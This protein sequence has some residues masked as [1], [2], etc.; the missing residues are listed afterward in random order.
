MR[1]AFF[2]LLLA[3]TA[4]CESAY[5]PN[6]PPDKEERVAQPS[7]DSVGEPGAGSRPSDAAATGGGTGTGGTATGGAATGEAATGTP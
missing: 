2:V 3:I 4:G 6:L 7:T 5:N 1:L